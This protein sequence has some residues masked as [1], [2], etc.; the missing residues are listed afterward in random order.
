MAAFSKEVLM[1]LDSEFAAQGVPLHARPLHAAMRI[2]GGTF[3]M[4]PFGVGDEADEIC[5]AYRNL[6]PGD[7]YWPG[8]GRGLAVAV[9]RV[10]VITFPVIFGSGCLT[11][12]DGLGF[13]SQSEWLSWCRSDS[14]ITWKSAYAL[15]DVHDL[16]FGRQIL[17]EGSQQLVYL[18]N[19]L[20]HLSDLAA[21]LA[22]T[23][24]SS[25]ASLQ[26][27]GLIAELAMKSAL[28]QLQVP[29]ER[30]KKVFGHSLPKLSAE[31]SRLHPH[32]EDGELL[33]ICGLIP[34]LVTSR[35]SAPGITRMRIA[36]LSLAVQFVAASAVR[37]FSPCD[38]A[39]DMRA[40]HARPR[41]DL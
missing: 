2:L 10:R 35:Y 1:Q 40:D 18:S 15:A 33:R 34:D 5:A 19:A 16:A 20:E 14:T 39:E 21:S 32:Q 37:R 6:F 13:E 4:G 7:D 26:P 27:I 11:V 23:G 17:P 9:D 38:M 36:E 31:L 28:L 12:H 3:A 24:S 29:I 41:F 25:G 30:L 8:A 22:H